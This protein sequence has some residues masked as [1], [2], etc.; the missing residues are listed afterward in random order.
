[1]PY[2]VPVLGGF[3]VGEAL[4]AGSLITENNVNDSNTK[5]LL[6]PAFVT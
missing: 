3:V 4:G 6:R 2:L 1:M 5:V